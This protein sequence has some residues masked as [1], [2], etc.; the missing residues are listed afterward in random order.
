MKRD[1]WLLSC[2]CIK[3]SFQLFISTFYINI[4]VLYTVYF[5]LYYVSFHTEFLLILL[6]HAYAYFKRVEDDILVKYFTIQINI[7]ICIIIINKPYFK[8]TVYN[9]R[10]QTETFNKHKS[11]VYF[12]V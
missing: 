2:N 11:C 7:L 10:K 5:I 4:H 1:D 12:I 6:P 8:D 9:E 3:P